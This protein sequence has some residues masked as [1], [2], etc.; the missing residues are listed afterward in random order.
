[1]AMAKT[2]H[3]RGKQN[4]ERP[5][6]IRQ[7]PGRGRIAPHQHER[8]EEQERRADEDDDYGIKIFVAVR[9]LTHADGVT[10]RGDPRSLARILPILRA[11]EKNEQKGDQ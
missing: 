6:Q 5:N 10:R 9:L 1:M 4:D 8:R 2:L 3:D 7:V 11:G